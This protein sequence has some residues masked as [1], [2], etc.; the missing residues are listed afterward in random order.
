MKNAYRKLENTPMMTGGA[1][2][3]Q[4]LYG[5]HCNLIPGIALEPF[6][7]TSTF[8]CLGILAAI[9]LYQHILLRLSEKQPSQINY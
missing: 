6:L 4:L 2:A 8:I 5:L 3:T 9:C 7:I 1:A